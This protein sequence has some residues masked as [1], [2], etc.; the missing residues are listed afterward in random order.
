MRDPVENKE[1]MLK[2]RKRMRKIDDKEDVGR[3]GMLD[4]ANPG[5]LF[6]LQGCKYNLFSKD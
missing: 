6:H 1:Q 2:K 5:S 3:K 4:I